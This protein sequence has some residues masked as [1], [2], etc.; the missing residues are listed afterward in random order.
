[1]MNGPG[2]G[3]YDYSSNIFS[4]KGGKIPKGPRGLDYGKDGGVGPG[5]YDVDT[6]FNRLMS[7]NGVKIGKASRGVNYSSD[8]PGPGQYD[9]SLRDRAKGGNLFFNKY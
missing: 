4:S 7:A 6:A 2:P 9:P 1:M 3:S 5:A 8:I